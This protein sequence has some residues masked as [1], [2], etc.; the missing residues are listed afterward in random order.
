MPPTQHKLSVL[1]F[2]LLRMSRRAQKE[3]SDDF[4]EQ[5]ALVQTPFSLISKIS[6][7]QDR[8]LSAQT[9]FI[10]LTSEVSLSSYTGAVVL[11]KTNE[12]ENGLKLAT[13][14]AGSHTDIEEASRKKWH[15][16]ASVHTGRTNF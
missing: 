4:L 10:S 5:R 8:R 1:D 14:L 12:S 3:I 15:A 11:Y 9:A 16:G 13:V 6:Y 2:S 7:I